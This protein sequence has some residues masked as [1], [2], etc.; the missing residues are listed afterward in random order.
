[1]KNAIGIDIGGTKIA[2]GIITESG[3]LLKRVDVKSDPS[4]R[5]KMFA[6]VLE[7]VGQVLEKSS[8]SLDD[9]EGIGVGIPGK[10]DCEN[11]VAISRSHFF[12]SLN[13]L[14]V[15]LRKYRYQPKFPGES[16]PPEK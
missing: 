9:I 8:Y 12:Q 15:Y 5:E 1:M 2:A 10:V 13:S 6:K 3:E 16:C 7:A 11:G 4:D 14:I